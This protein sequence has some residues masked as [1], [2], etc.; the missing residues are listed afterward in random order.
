M[1]STPKRPPAAKALGKSTGEHAGH[2]SRFK[3]ISD[4]SNGRLISQGVRQPIAPPV[5]Q[6]LKPKVAQPKTAFARA[7]T[8]ASAHPAK[9]PVTQVAPTKT[10]IRKTPVTRISFRPGTPVQPVARVV[11]RSTDSAVPVSFKVIHK[12]NLVPELKGTTTSGMSVD[13]FAKRGREVVM[14]RYMGPASTGRTHYE[15][16][17]EIRGLYGKT[18]YVKFHFTSAGY[19]AIYNADPTRDDGLK[20]Y[21]EAA[22]TVNAN[23]TEKL[24]G[25]FLRMAARSY[26]AGVY[27]C[28][29]FA[30]DFFRAVTGQSV[31]EEPD[32]M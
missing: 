4:P 15:V 6:P 7:T 30:A 8:P 2:D 18:K 11:Q 1:N 26:R 32:F 27:T 3:P 25:I 13:T 24:Y 5:Y 17:C 9:R 23:S 16:M 31:N 14:C 19:F 29:N 22:P 12:H 28:E 21:K 20:V 10:G